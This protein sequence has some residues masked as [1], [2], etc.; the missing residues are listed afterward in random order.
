MPEVSNTT[1][2][3]GVP[4]VLSMM[5]IVTERSVDPFRTMSNIV[6]IDHPM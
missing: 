5:R 1:P 3:S 2:V 4:S 6:A